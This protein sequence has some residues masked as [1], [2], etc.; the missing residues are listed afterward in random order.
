MLNVILSLVFALSGAVLILLS[1]IILR[2]NPRGRINRVTAMMLFFA[3]MA[4]VMATI[5]YSVIAGS[6][7]DY[8][9]RVL[10]FFYIW[11]LFFPS[12][13]LFSAI[14]PV[15]NPL[16]KRRRRLFYLAFLPHIVHLILVLFFSDPSGL[17]SKLAI[18]S[19]IPIFGILLEYIGYIL[20]LIVIGINAI[21]EFHVRFFSIINLVYIVVA[22]IFLYTGYR[23]V[24]NPRIRQQVKIITYGIRIALGLYIL[25]YIIPTIFNIELNPQ[26]Q[27]MMIIIGLLV[28]PGFIAWAILR[29]RFLDITLI[30]RQ[31]LVYTVSSAIVVGGYLVAMS[32]VGRFLSSVF[33]G[34][35]EVFQ[36]AIMVIALLFF[37]PVLNFVDTSLRKLFIKGKTDYRVILEDFSSKILTLLDI[38]KLIDETLRTIGDELLI[39]R[40]FLAL[41]TDNGNYSIHSFSEEVETKIKK[42]RVL[43]SFLIVREAPVTRDDIPA[44]ALSAT[45]REFLRNKKTELIIPLVA[46]HRLI[47]FIGLGRKASGMGY[48]SE[49]ITIFKVLASQLMVAF[50]NAR[51]YQESL[52]RQR[53]EEE[54]ALARQIQRQLLPKSVPRYGNIKF[55][56]YSEPSREVGGDFYDF[57]MTKTNRLAFGIGDASGKG[58][59]ASLLIARMQAILHS[60]ANSDLDVSAKIAH[61]NNVLSM[62]SSEGR[63]VTFFYGEVDTKADRIQYCNAGHNYPILIRQN[64]DCEY[65]KDGGLL[66]GVFGDVSYVSQAIEFSRGDLLACYTDGVTE[67]LNEKE[68]EFG[69]DRLLDV[70]SDN[71]HLPLD[72]LQETV[73]DS[74]KLHCNGYPIQDDCTMLIMR[75]E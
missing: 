69:E 52:E 32:Q 27:Y 30:V 65:L 75:I 67:A 63:F 23:N 51:L 17:L 41:P 37:Q 3:G 5:Y 4:P 47:G 35:L 45:I 56:T 50:S 24:A 2:E 11:E 55:A 10:N 57:L 44:P 74:I 73:L 21:F 59:P 60:V 58:I 8:S 7:S 33:G 13:L 1:G 43:E 19:D 25:A 53:L 70:L 68:V 64:G 66:L 71:R 6:G 29:H 15:E 31:S 16:F 38:N 28:G 46:S 49:D 36:V 72:K 20:A 62:G 54:L 42:D 9:P 26:L 40:V 61:I 48:N 14:F 39:E 34:G 18:K 22:S 12:F